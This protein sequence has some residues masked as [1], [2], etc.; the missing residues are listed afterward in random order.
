M[1]ILTITNQ[2]EFE[3]AQQE[4]FGLGFDW[5]YSGSN[6]VMTLDFTAGPILLN[7]NLDDKTLTW[8]RH[9]PNDA[10]LAFL[11]SVHGL[12]PNKE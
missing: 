11:R 6:F 5:K 9:T 1:A 8:E 7:C 2:E 3:S 10:V 12:T 4:L